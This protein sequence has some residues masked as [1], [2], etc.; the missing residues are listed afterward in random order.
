MSIVRLDREKVLEFFDEIPIGSPGHA[1][2]VCAVAGEDLGAGLLKRYLEKEHLAQVSILFGPVGQGTRKGSKLDRWI[3]VK[4]PGGA[5]V[6]Y[7]VEIKNWSAHAIGGKRLPVKILPDALAKWKQT[8][9]GKL[10]NKDAQDFGID[11][12]KKVLTRMKCPDT[13][14]T[15][16][17]VACLW[18]ALHPEGATSPWF[19]VPI[20]RKDCCFRRLH[21]FSMSS[22]LRN[23]N[24]SHIEIEMPDIVQRLDWL[25]KM[26]AP[27]E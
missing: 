8:E 21:V 16:E 6:Y 15:V 18:I 14:A 7:Q 23:L 24:E 12:L 13:S 3:S 1:T 17:P 9:W 25:Q 20:D 2:S 11:S 26:F 4:Y 22:Y 27:V 5:T 10:W 19:E